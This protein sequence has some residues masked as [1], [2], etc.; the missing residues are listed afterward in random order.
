[1]FR[2]GF[3][4]VQG[5]RA[6]KMSGAFVMISKWHFSACELSWPSRRHMQGPQSRA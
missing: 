2:L 5:Y 3:R 1:M 4:G 6:S